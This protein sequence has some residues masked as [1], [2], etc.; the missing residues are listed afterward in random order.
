MM[1]GSRVSKEKLNEL[2]EVYEQLN[3]N[4]AAAARAIK[5]SE[6]TARQN[7]NKYYFNHEAPPVLGRPPNVSRVFNMDVYEFVYQMTLINPTLYNWEIADL[8]KQY[9]DIGTVDPS[10]ISRIRHH[11]LGFHHVK[12][13]NLSSYRNQPHIKMLKEL[14]CDYMCGED[15]NDFIFLDECSVHGTDLARKYAYTIPNSNTLNNN[16]ICNQCKNLD[17]VSIT[18]AVNGK[19][20]VAYMLKPLKTYGGTKAKDIIHFIKSMQSANL[21]SPQNVIMFDNATIHVCKEVLNWLK[22]H[23]IRYVVNAPYCPELNLIEYCFGLM[24]SFLKYAGAARTLESVI[25]S[26][27]DDI[28][29]GHMR[30]FLNY[31]YQHWSEGRSQIFQQ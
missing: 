15:I 30:Q 21:I 20:V 23:N 7:I 12:A 6:T 27:I 1:R 4:A 26:A 5:I 13:N 3:Y 17:T 2:F 31:T 8:V 10:N 14:W 16:M 24:K 22:E 9:L 19:G 28:T 29:P 11:I 25:D 18:M